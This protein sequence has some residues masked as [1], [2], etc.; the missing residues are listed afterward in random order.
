MRCTAQVSGTLTG[1]VVDPTGARLARATVH[2]VQQAGQAPGAGADRAFETDRAGRFSAALPPGTYSLTASAPGFSVGAER[3][4]KLVAGERAEVTLRLSIEARTDTVDVT[5]DAGASTSARDNKGALVF[6]QERLAEL[7]DDEA[8]M[9]QQLLA[10]SGGDPSHPPDVYVDGFQGGRFP[11]KSSIREVRINQNPYSAEYPSYGSNRMEI[12]TQPGG[13][14]LHGHFY[15]VGNDA[16]F[17]ANN[18]YTQI[19]PPYYSYYL[20]GDV[21]GPLIDKKTSFFLDFTLHNMQNNSVINAIDPVGFGPL[22]QAVSTPDN[23]RTY[24]ARLDRQMTP[25]NTLTG[26]F[27]QEHETLTNAGVGML[28]LASEAY[29]STNTMQTLQLSDTQVVSP[30]IIAETRFQYIRTRA[31]QHAQNS[32]PTVV[33]EGSLNGGGSSVGVQHANQDRYEFQEYVS[34]AKGKHFVRTGGRYDL[35]RDANESTA[36]YNGTYLFSSLAAYRANTPAQF[37]VTTGN[38]NA[39]LTSG[40]LGAF[41]ED[42][43]KATKNLTLDLGLRFET[44]SAVPDHAD[45]APRLGAAWSVGQ[46]DKKPPIVVVRAGYGLFYQRFS[47]SDL[48]TSVRQNGVSQQNHIVQNPAICPAATADPS[49]PFPLCAGQLNAVAP[50]PYLVSPHLRTE[51]DEDAGVAVERDLGKKGNLSLTYVW[52]HGAHQYLSE[53]INAPLPGTYNPA[54]AASGVRPMGGTQN[55]YEFV[56]EGI[57]KAH[58]LEVSANLQPTKRLSMW[59]FYVFQNE[60]DNILNSTSF[61]SNSYDLR[62]DYGQSGRLPKQRLYTGGDLNLPW[63]MSVDTFMAAGS[64]IPFNITTGTDLNGDTIYNDRPS[65]ATDLTRASVVR[66]RFGNFDTSPIAGQQMIPVN[67]GNSPGYLTVAMRL[68]KTV[69]FGP[70]APVAGMAGK[71]A[72]NPPTNPPTKGE[73]PYSIRFGI[74]AQNLFN[75]VNPAQPIGVL[76]SPLFGRSIS[77]LK[78]FTPLQAANRVVDVTLNFAF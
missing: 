6:G 21:S 59:A 13:D 7:S 53:N 18:P 46:R 30:K 51:Y 78:E 5:P 31:Q 1:S 64:G 14:H 67:Y 54:N 57:A 23:T 36:N 41:A 15:G 49:N 20:Y 71:P 35:E 70:R 50:T 12:F 55:I 66:T 16:P 60:R 11:P 28:A 3:S 58:V 48:L 33:V 47:P 74:S 43:F 45:W 8:M 69:Q 10:M 19:E 38:A 27:D 61:A 34:F 24:T 32:S 75:S 40:W 72:T 25:S 62:A 76:N 56:S 44:Q 77:L 29:D 73:A 37:S 26:R 63:N 42:E 2:V 22:S 65:F 4:V 68:G 9:Q 17:N 52:A 39:V